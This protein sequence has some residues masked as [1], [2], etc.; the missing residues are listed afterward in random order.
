[1]KCFY[2]NLD[3]ATDRRQSIEASFQRAARPGWSLE[4]IAAF[5][6]AYVEKAAV[7]GR[8]RPAEKAC[9]LSHKEAVRRS[10]AHEGPVFI[11]EDDV[12]FSDKTFAVLEALLA[13][14]PTAWDL[15]FTDISVAHMG[16]MIELAVLKIQM[17]ATRAVKTLNLRELP[18][19]S[20]A[21]YLVHEGAKT[22]FL[23]IMDAV[24]SFDVA[25]DSFLNQSVADGKLE[26]H[27]IFPFLTTLSDLA[28]ASDI[29]S[30]AL[31]D[32]NTIL[33]LF[34]KLV[35][36]DGSAAQ[37]RETLAAITQSTSEEARAFGTLWS[38]MIDKDFL[39]H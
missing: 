32:G 5:D 18:F 38:A 31:R 10:L 24:T 1:M 15:W 2:I 26:A 9:F 34:R 6:A 35:W 16:S 39:R 11:L 29:Q 12:I 14:P 28:G 19:F 7:P 23:G 33:N 21:A 37:H 36:I 3:R 27:A 20:S 13:R 30:G 8:I 17:D 4:R 25:Y 22:K